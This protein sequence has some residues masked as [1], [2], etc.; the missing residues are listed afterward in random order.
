MGTLVTLAQLDPET[1]ARATGVFSR[2]CSVYGLTAGLFRA[3]EIGTAARDAAVSQG[4]ADAG[5]TERMWE[6]L[7]PCLYRKM[8]DFARK[9][10]NVPCHLDAAKYVV[11]RRGLEQRFGALPDSAPALPEEEE[12]ADSP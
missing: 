11:L 5:F 10:Q 7:L 12:G 9:G 8:A 3:D 2:F 4:S 6:L 1:Q